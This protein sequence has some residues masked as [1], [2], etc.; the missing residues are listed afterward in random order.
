MWLEEK[1]EEN[2][3]VVAERS[4]ARV[5]PPSHWVTMAPWGECWG[6]RRV[7]VYITMEC[8]LNCADGW[9]KVMGDKVDERKTEREGEWLEEESKMEG[10]CANHVFASSRRCVCGEY[11]SFFLQILNETAQHS[12]FAKK[13]KKT[14]PRSFRL[15]ATFQHHSSTILTQPMTIHYHAFIHPRNGPH[16]S[17]VSPIVTFVLYNV[18]VYCTNFSFLSLPTI[19]FLH[20]NLFNQLKQPWMPLRSNCLVMCMVLPIRENTTFCPCLDN[21]PFS[22]AYTFAC[23]CI[24]MTICRK[25][26]S[27]LYSIT[28]ICSILGHFPTLSIDCASYFI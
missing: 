16:K 12:C 10:G 3:G 23:K 18:L 19:T 7:C 20:F 21:V 27:K 5:M 8:S 13:R 2:G 28:N 6:C 11:R 17:P 24:W 26:W 22:T 14:W 15:I 4:K 25:M 9:D 1:Q